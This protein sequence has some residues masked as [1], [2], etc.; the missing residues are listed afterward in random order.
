MIE[1]TAL[2]GPGAELYGGG[3]FTNGAS[4]HSAA[5]VEGYLGVYV[6]TG[7][8]AT[9]TNYGTIEGTGAAV[10]F[11]SSTDVLV[12]EAGGAIVGKDAAPASRALTPYGAKDHMTL[13]PGPSGCSDSGSTMMTARLWR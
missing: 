6:H 12:V 11:G 8:T 9:I 10:R 4:G 3:S 1:A 5:L 7:E 13:W 2:S